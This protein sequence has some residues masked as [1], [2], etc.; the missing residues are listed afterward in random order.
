M[1]GTN[2]KVLISACI[3]LI[4]MS[5]QSFAQQNNDQKLLLGQWILEQET[6][7]D[8]KYPDFE[9]PVEINIQEEDIMFVRS[10]STV[11]VKF[12]T[13]VK[14]RVFCFSVCAEW[15]ITDDK[16]QLSW[17]QDIETQDGGSQ[18]F[19]ITYSRK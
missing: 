8:G 17:D 7:V 2:F 1:E 3:L 10:E 6:S 11:Q 5:V 4:S 19:I 15:S 13:V 9:I 18:T 12:N 14:G 16:L